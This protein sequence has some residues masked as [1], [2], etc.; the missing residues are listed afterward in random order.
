M[1]LKNNYA[2]SSVHHKTHEGWMALMV[3]SLSHYSI[4]HRNTRVTFGNILGD[5][6]F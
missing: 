1:A 4:I 3:K 6:E 5:P 2:L